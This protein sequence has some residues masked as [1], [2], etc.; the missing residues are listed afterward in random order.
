M[1]MKNL[2]LTI[3]F[4]MHHLDNIFLEPTIT[5]STA[6]CL[7]NIFT[8]IGPLK[9]EIIDKHIPISVDRYVLLL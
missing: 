1:R 5:A 7:D 3:S 9:K 4:C 8:D 6:R 2:Y